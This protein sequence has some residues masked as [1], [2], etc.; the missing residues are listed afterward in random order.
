M[1]TQYL[2]NLASHWT[3]AHCWPL[4]VFFRKPSHPANRPEVRIRVESKAEVRAARQN[5]RSS[6]GWPPVQ[7]ISKDVEITEDLELRETSIIMYLYSPPTQSPYFCFGGLI[8]FLGKNKMEA[9]GRDFCFECLDF[10]KCWHPKFPKLR[11][12]PR[13][14]RKWR[15]WHR[16]CE[17]G[18]IRWFPTLKQAEV[19]ES[20]PGLGQCEI[21]KNPKCRRPEMER[22][23][24]RQMDF[25]SLASTFVQITSNYIPTTHPHLSALSGSC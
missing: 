3:V 9:D 14:G 12:L 19:L 22:R 2:N 1:H 17:S 18:G 5:Q 20:L 16:N 10:R 8:F 11:S 24:P 21:Q 15:K 25:A 7:D 4:H 23:K 13:E 6:C